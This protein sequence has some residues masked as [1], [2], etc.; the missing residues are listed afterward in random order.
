MS[1]LTVRRR[2]SRT[3]LMRTLIVIPARHGSTRF[4]A[5]PLAEIAG[6]TLLARVTR[7]AERVCQ[8]RT[9]AR[10]VIATDHDE[11]RAHAEAIAAPVVMTDPDLPSGTDRA[12]AAAELSDETPDFVLNLQGD[13]PFTPPAHL[14]ALISA[15]AASQADVVTPVIRLTWEALDTVRDQKTREPFSGTSCVRRA[16]GLALWFSKQVLPAIRKEDRL[17]TETPL[18]PVFRHIGLY[19]YTMA[20][21]RRFTALPTGYYEALEGLEQLRFL[22][23]GMSILTVEVEPGEA[24]MWGV[25]TPEDAGFA[26]QLIA[27]HGDPHFAG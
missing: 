19:G 18:S 11:I 15:A 16:D 2:T 13:A 20:A 23:N 26:E 7:I 1:G 8:A 27:R 24:A 22:E 12:L 10:F 5:K 17:R 21:L 4:P 14:E 9:D 25:D 6:V 3:A